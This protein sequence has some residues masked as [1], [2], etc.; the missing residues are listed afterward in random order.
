MIG[1]VWTYDLGGWTV[2]VPKVLR[3][4]RRRRRGGKGMGMGRGCPPPQ[5]TWGVWGS[6][7]SSSSGVRGRAPQRKTNLEHSRAARKPLVAMN[8]QIFEAK[9]LLEKTLK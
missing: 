2:E 8:L 4:R 3:T 6:I 9:F 5:P 7:V 1:G